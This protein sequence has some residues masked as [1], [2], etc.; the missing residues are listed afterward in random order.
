MKES[1]TKKEHN[2]KTKIKRNERQDLIEA[3]G[4]LN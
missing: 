2:F 1:E 4:G 3:L